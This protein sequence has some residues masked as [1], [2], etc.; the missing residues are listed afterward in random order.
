MSIFTIFPFG[1]AGN[2]AKFFCEW[3]SGGNSP[4]DDLIIAI[5]LQ[6]AEIF[7]LR[8]N[9]EVC[10]RSIDFHLVGHQ[11]LYCL[12]HDFYHRAKVFPVFGDIF[13]REVYRHDRMP[14]KYFFCFKNRQVSLQSSVNQQPPVHFPGFEYP[15]Y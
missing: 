10:C 14:R 7:D 8:G 6:D 12:S 11:Y 5:R 2:I 1:T 4:R 15:W 3:F 9:Q 13:R